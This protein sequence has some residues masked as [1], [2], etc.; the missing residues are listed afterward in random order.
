[1]EFWSYHIFLYLFY[2]IVDRT[3]LSSFVFLALFW[4][5]CCSFRIPLHYNSVHFCFFVFKQLE[6]LSIQH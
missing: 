2:K 1:M 4:Q 5:L 3:L 6:I